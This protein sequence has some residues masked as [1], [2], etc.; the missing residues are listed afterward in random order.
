M[1][2]ELVDSAYKKKVT[3]L[4]REKSA[5]HLAFPDIVVLSTTLNITVDNVAY[6]KEILIS[7]PKLKSVES[8]LT[9]NDRGIS[10]LE[11]YGAYFYA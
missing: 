10:D 2:K 8:K 7:D 11:Y 4:R 6:E 5:E 9:D 3:A 1:P